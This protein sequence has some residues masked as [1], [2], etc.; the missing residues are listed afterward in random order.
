MIVVGANT[1][2]Y[3]GEHR[4]QHYF[5]IGLQYSTPY[6]IPRVPDQAEVPGDVR[7]ALIS[8][9]SALLTGAYF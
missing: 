5:P 7:L 4:H 8:Q 6:S 1:L 9:V 2:D 3:F